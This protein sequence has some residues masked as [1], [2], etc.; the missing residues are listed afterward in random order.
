MFHRSTL[1]LAE[2]CAKCRLNMFK[3]VKPK[4]LWLAASMA[5]LAP[6]LHFRVVN[7]ASSISS[8]EAQIASYNLAHDSEMK[9][10]K[11]ALLCICSKLES[12]EL[13][14]REIWA[15]RLS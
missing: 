8:L 13:S 14:F 1:S 12:I 4:V 9:D 2:T 15:G 6:S 10:A 11:E 5:A 7:H 3:V